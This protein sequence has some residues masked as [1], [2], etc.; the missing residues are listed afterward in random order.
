MKVIS[1]YA[2][3]RTKKAEVS[4]LNK[5]KEL[6]N[7]L[8]IDSNYTVVLAIE[9]E[10]IVLNG[11]IGSGDIRQLLLLRHI[12]DNSIKEVLNEQLKTTLKEVKND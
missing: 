11:I 7:G 3:K 8:R 12:T 1:N 9:S 4:G 2:G 6:I 10:K 5:L